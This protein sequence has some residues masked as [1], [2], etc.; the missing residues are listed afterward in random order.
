MVRKN[1]R[2]PTVVYVHPAKGSASRSSG[3]SGSI[4]RASEPKPE[5]MTR[6]SEADKQ[7]LKMIANYHPEVVSNPAQANL[8]EA[9]QRRKLFIFSSRTDN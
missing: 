5:I 8:S 9:N 3:I 4:W 1:G 6:N 2:V 7:I